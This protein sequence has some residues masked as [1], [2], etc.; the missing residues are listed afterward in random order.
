MP[1]AV[2]SESFR[3]KRIL[4]IPFNMPMIKNNR[5]FHYNYVRLD[6]NLHVLAEN[7]KVNTAAKFCQLKILSIYPTNSAINANMESTHTLEEPIQPE[8]NGASAGNIHNL[9][10]DVLSYQLQMC[11]RATRE[12]I[13]GKWEIELTKFIDFPNWKE[14]IDAIASIYAT[15]PNYTKALIERVEQYHLYQFDLT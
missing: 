5:P 14:F 9:N 8:W 3:L 2:C 12:F 11:H 6:G 10:S 4:A 15:D 7:P 1:F 13:K